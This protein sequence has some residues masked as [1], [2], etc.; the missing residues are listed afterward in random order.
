VT[1]LLLVAV[2]VLVA[3]N[4]FFVAAEFALVRARRSRVEVLE[5]E[6]SRGAFCVCASVVL[7]LTSAN[8]A[9]TKKPFRRMKT[10]AKKSPSTL[11]AA[12]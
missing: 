3:L 4:G 9:A 8:S 1:A 2:L 6:G 7:I 12:L 11:G 10:A 5:E